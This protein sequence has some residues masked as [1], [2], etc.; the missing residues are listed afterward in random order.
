MKVLLFGADGFIG[1]HVAIR[2]QKDHEI[3]LVT[4]SDSTR[5]GHVCVDL[6]DP[7]SITR[8]LTSVKPDAVINCAG[9][10]TND[11]NA[12][13][14]VVFTQNILNGVLGLKL[15]LKH[16]VICGSAAEYGVVKPTYLPVKE[17]ASTNA[18]SPYGQCKQK[19][20]QLAITYKQKHNLPITVLR[21]FNPIGSGMHPRLLIPQMIKQVEEIKLGKREF[22]EISRLDSERDY[23]NVKDVAV[24]FSQLLQR[25][26]PLADIYNVGS[27]VSTSNQ[28]LL[29]LIVRYSGLE[30]MPP[31]REF[32][33]QPEPP[34]A[35]R[36]DI[37]LAQQD[38]GWEPKYSIEQMIKELVNASR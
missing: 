16:L 28:H 27:G 21:I 30:N 37:H 5:A 8:A 3:T 17:G 26:K 34:V 1:K 19:E 29:E 36:A 6:T 14:N 12:Q 18:T 4:R 2:L 13:L 20:T 32:M 33:E 9:V 22:I 11:E 15:H 10:V 25:S 23:I 31:V 7:A 38:L 35:S 24:C